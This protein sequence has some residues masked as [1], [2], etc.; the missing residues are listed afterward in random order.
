MEKTQIQV[1]LAEDNPADVILLGE[2][3]EKDALTSFKITPVE[4]LVTAIDL[5][6]KK[7]F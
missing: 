5:L 4:R 2:A 3:L 6:K 7:P 1:L